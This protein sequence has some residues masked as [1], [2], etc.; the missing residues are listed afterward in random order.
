LRSQIDPNEKRNLIDKILHD[1]RKLLSE[2]KPEESI[3]NQLQSP[4]ENWD[5]LVNKDVINVESEGNNT[6]EGQIYNNLSKINKNLV[7]N[8]DS[9][10]PLNR[11]PD[12]QNRKKVKFDG[13]F[14]NSGELEDPKTKTQSQYFQ[15]LKNK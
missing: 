1:R 13:G 8:S 3:N 5:D 14:N 9:K 11:S 7:F 15:K 10:V 6:I 12:Y 4:E 2:K